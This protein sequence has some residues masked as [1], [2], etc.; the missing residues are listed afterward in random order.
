MT[1]AAKTAER[2]DLFFIDEPAVDCSSLV[3]ITSS[4]R[5]ATSRSIPL[6]VDWSNVAYVDLLGVE[7]VFDYLLERSAP[8]AFI[9]VSREIEH[10][11]RR[12]QIL[13][14]LP[15]A[16]TDEVAKRLIGAAR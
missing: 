4:L 6:I 3:R 16:E 5:T 11:F 15:T 13:A 8:V 9:G 10:L 14:V 1:E 7:S 12:L 2:Y